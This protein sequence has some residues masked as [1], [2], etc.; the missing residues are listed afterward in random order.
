[1]TKQSENKGIFLALTTAFISG[2][3]IFINKFGVKGINP[4]LFTSLKNLTVAVLIFSLIL[5]IKEKKRLFRLSKKDW[6][7]LFIIGL[8][9]GSVPFFLFFKGLTLTSAAQA[10]FIHKNMFLLIALLAFI[11]LKEKVSKRFFLAALLLLLGNSLILKTYHFSLNKGDLLILLATFLWAIENTI[12]K[13]AVASFSPKIVAFGRMFFGSFLMLLFLTLTNQ[14]SPTSQL[15]K[16]QIGWITITSLFLLGYVLSWYS[17]LKYARVSLAASI[18]PLGSPIT[19]ILS[20]FFLRKI[21]DIKNVLSGILI[22]LG[23]IFVAELPTV[24]LSIATVCYLSFKR[25]SKNLLR[26][27]RYITSGGDPSS[28]PADEYSE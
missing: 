13:K 15:T 2:I 4:Y 6:L 25:W 19:T 12:S 24:I 22:V 14:I 17:A 16:L 9:G 3:S 5:G 18:L 20:L 23:I 7:V 26:M 27:Q 8:I 28:P 21:P 10:S 1:M 11:F